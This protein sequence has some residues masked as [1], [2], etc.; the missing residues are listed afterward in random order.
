[1]RYTLTLAPE[2]AAAWTDV[3]LA[4]TLS[5]YLTL[6][7]ATVHPRP[8]PFV[9]PTKSSGDEGATVVAFNG[10]QRPKTSRPVKVSVVARVSKTAPL[11]EL[12]G[13]ITATLC[14]GPVAS[15]DVR[16]VRKG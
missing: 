6:R 11:S 2:D 15:L 16:V 14:S 8:K 5:P 1:M 12:P 7:K 4:V 9:K 3:D 10:L 13:A